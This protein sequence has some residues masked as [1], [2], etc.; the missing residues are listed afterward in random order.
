M[1]KEL[2][3]LASTTQER[4]LK[5][6]FRGSRVRQQRTKKLGSKKVTRLTHPGDHHRTDEVIDWR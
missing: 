4:L 3:Q 6:Y 5:N 1:E 2:S